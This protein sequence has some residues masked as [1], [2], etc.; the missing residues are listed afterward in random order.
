MS[1]YTDL[2]MRRRENL[3]VLRKPGS[4]DD[5][6]TPQRVIFANPEN[7]Y[8]GTFKGK[9]DASGVNLSNVTLT[10]VTIAGGK[11]QD[12]TI[13]SE[14]RV[15]SIAELTSNV[16]ELSGRVDG[17]FQ[18]I[19]SM[20]STVDDELSSLSVGIEQNVDGK[21]SSLSLDFA[22]LAD[23]LSTDINIRL[24]DETSARVQ[25]DM[26][27]DQK[28]SS[29]AGTLSDV[30]DQ[31]SS[32]ELSIDT[33]SK[34]IS[35][36]T[37]GM[38]HYH[39]ALLNGYGTHEN[40]VQFL[41][42][43][44]NRY[45]YA[46]YCGDQYKITADVEFIGPRQKSLYADDY[47][48]FNRDIVLSAVR[49]DSIDIIRDAQAEGEHIKS[50]VDKISSDLSTLSSEV[51]S[52]YESLTT[53]I[54]NLSASVKGLSSEI[55]TISSILSNGIDG[56]SNSIGILS[57][58]ISGLS[59]EVKDISS[60]LSN[61]IGN[62]SSSLSSYSAT[63]SGID[64]EADGYDDIKSDNLIV[65]DVITKAGAHAHD[66]YYMSFLSGTVVMRPIA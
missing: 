47:I 11:I 23:A 33:M 2:H 38:M 22:E 57:S 16:S 34:S 43:N 31:I 49:F 15:I 36:Q 66:R 24:S 28:I 65:T 17:A 7:I 3:T 9:I 62:L 5:G 55:A 4:P 64:R 60:I 18:K 35:A 25:Q 30:Q 6:I 32:I 10:D 19:D 54:D 63:L 29:A 52:T 50:L 21:L 41:I 20:S 53:D 40:I 27:L 13:Y 46:F 42:E 56:L 48:L 61:D 59:S 12:A 58:T 37:V 51:G 8:E 44:F 14:G 45:D 1:T 39:G 26:L